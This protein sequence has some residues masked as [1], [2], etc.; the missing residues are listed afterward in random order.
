M[1]T[2]EIKVVRQL[3]HVLSNFKYR[4]IIGLGAVV[5]SVVLLS[6][7]IQTGSEDKINLGKNLR[8]AVPELD[9]TILGSGNEAF[10]QVTDQKEGGEINP[11]IV[12]ISGQGR[13]RG[14]VLNSRKNR[15]YDAFYNIPYARPPVGRLRFEPPKSPRRWFGIRD[16]SKP[17]KEC[18]QKEKYSP[19]N[20]PAGEE[21]CLYL[22][23]YRP[24]VPETSQNKPLP[25]MLYIHGGGV[26]GNGTRY[27]AKYFMDEDVILVTFEY[28]LGILGHFT[29]G[30][31]EYPGNIG[32]RDRIQA[33]KWLQDNIAAFG[34]DPKRV[35][36]FG[37]SSGAMYVHELLFSPMSEGLFSKAIIQSGTTLPRNRVL[38][39]SAATIRTVTEQVGCG[40]HV[41]R[42]Q[43]LLRCLRKVNA[44]EIV[45]NPLQASFDGVQI[46]PLAKQGDVSESYMPDSPWNMIQAGGS[47]KVPVIIGVNSLEVLDPTILELLFGPN[48]PEIMEDRW[49]EVVPLLLEVPDDDNHT[50][51]SA[52]YD[53]Y[54][55]DDGITTDSAMGVWNLSADT[56]LHSSRVSGMLHSKTTGSPVYFY[57]LSKEPAKSYGS[58]TKDIYPAHGASHADELQYMFLYYGYPEITT[59]SPWFPFSETLVK[60]WA[61]FASTGQPATPSVQWDPIDLADDGMK[62]FQLDDEMKTVEYFTERM[63]VWDEFIPQLYIVNSTA[64][65]DSV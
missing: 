23:I 33:L 58:T 19:L 21:D 15:N 31:S 4:V 3:Q 30:T 25:V 8:R 56:V 64:V 20:I 48:G 53:V 26:Y 10:L 12:R 11:P 49:N 59:T 65:K 1:T 13:V 7:T 61:S 2:S 14:T 22:N 45:L 29:T 5:V 54:I 40:A 17:G 36:I 42:T 18:I 38:S 35:V 24:H 9:L 60:L 50:M 52:L 47:H 44:T 41:N 28:R 55:G 46:E 16:A 32:G 39:N 51:A 6:V 57:W 63:L 27:G 62:W 43:R 34:G 37:N